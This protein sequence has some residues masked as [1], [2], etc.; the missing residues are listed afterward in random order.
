MERMEPRTR[1]Y[2]PYP[3]DERATAMFAV[4]G[5]VGWL[6]EQDP[7]WPVGLWASPAN[8]YMASF[9]VP[10]GFG[11]VGASVL[12]S[13]D[14]TSSDHSDRTGPTDT[15]TV[16]A[17]SLW[18]AITT[19]TAD[20]FGGMYLGYRA[21]RPARGNAPPLELIADWH[22]L[23]E[24]GESEFRSFCDTAYA[25]DGPPAHGG[26]QCGAMLVRPAL[27]AAAALVRPFVVGDPSDPIGIVYAE[28]DGRQGLFGFKSAL[29]EMP[30]HP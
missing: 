10:T 28:R 29:T 8:Q 19:S 9:A 22:E 25:P 1:T 27:V 18:R 2:T 11:E 24:T 23:G 6:A 16:T 12:L 3:E 17:A 20:N 14:Y 5:I 13:F 30:H 4:L 15:R 21:L 26:V 7:D